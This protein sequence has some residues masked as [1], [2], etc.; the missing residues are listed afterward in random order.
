MLALAVGTS[1]FFAALFW[2]WER[3]L[4]WMLV[5]M[6]PPIWSPVIYQRFGDDTRDVD[7][8]A[9]A[10][11]LIGLALLVGVGLLLYVVV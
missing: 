5:V 3:D 2:I 8:T 7:R 1:L 6:L 11:S 9:V 10:A 4:L